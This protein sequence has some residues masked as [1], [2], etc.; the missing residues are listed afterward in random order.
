M[1]SLAP[2]EATEIQPATTSTLP[3]KLAIVLALAALADFLFYDARIGLSLAVFAIAVAGG[4]WLVNRTIPDR[5]R[6]LIGAVVLFVGL[7]PVIE[8][9]STVS[10]L[11]VIMAL[12]LGL[13]LATNPDTTTLGDGARALRN[14]FLFGP[15]RFFLEVLQ[16]FNMSS[17]TRGIA[18]WFLPAVLGIVFIALFAAANPLIEQ[19]VTLLNPKLILDYVSVGRILFWAMMLAVIWPFI[20]VRWRKRRAKVAAEVAERE[21]ALSARAE[22]LGA[23]TILRSL[24]LFNVLFAAQSGLDAL[25]LW[26]HAAL[27]AGVTYAAYAHRGAYPLIVTA[28]LAAA[29]VLV[30]MRPGGPAEKSPVIRLLVYIWV[31]QNVLLVASSILRL[32]IYVAIYLLTYW[33]IAAFIWMGLVALGLVLIVARIMLDR[34]NQWLIGANLIALTSVLYIVSLVNFDAIIAD[35]NVTHS[36][37]VSGKGV[38]IDVNYLSQLGPQA[39]PAIEKVMQL[40]PGETCLVGRRDRLVELQRLDMASWRTWG[41]RSWRLQRRLDA[42]AKNPA[43]SQGAG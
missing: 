4:S 31:G 17:F 30:A 38:Q 40:R 41:F 8:E 24:I 21:P 10:V 3:F 5:R 42:Q 43:K 13:L 25:Y 14:L 33:R 39:L 22:F 2:A 26:G 32:D 28:L 18:A 23:P 15:F 12:A 7:V 37:E 1:T 9:V 16:V 6:A 34:S 20:H 35:Y 11:F 29:F 36:R 27:P 19:W